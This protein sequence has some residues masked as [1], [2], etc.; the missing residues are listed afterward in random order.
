MASTQP[1]HNRRR[2]HSAT[3]TQMISFHQLGNTRKT[4]RDIV[5]EYL[6][7]NGAANSRTIAERCHIERTATTR[8]LKD[9]EQDEKIRIADIRRCNVT[10]RPVQFYEVRTTYVQGSL[11]TEQTNTGE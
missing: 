1:T 8:V 9:L 10:G 2:P 3:V 5:L 4:Q 11:F 6:T 7:S